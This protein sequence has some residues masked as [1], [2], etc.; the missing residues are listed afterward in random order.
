MVSEVCFNKVVRLWKGL[1]GEMYLWQIYVWLFQERNYVWIFFQIF[2][3]D[4]L[5]NYYIVL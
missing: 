3:V 4:I 1:K 5:G 2:V